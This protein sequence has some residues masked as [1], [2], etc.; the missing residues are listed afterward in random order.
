MN[1][2]LDPMAI[3]LQRAM[4]RELLNNEPDADQAGQQNQQ[5]RHTSYRCFVLWQYN[6]LGASDP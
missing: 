3:V 6:R 2:I 1:Q 5:S 4:W